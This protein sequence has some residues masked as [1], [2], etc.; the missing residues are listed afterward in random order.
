MGAFGKII[1][2]HYED[3][4]SGRTFSN[5][6]D[7]V[8]NP[9]A[10]FPS[11]G[12]RTE[13]DIHNACSGPP[14]AAYISHWHKDTRTP[15]LIG[16]KVD[17]LNW[18]VY[19]YEDRVKRVASYVGCVIND[20][21]ERFCAGHARARL[22]L[23]VRDYLNIQTHVLGRVKEEIEI[24]GFDSEAPE[25]NKSGF[26]RSLVSVDANVKRGLVWLINKGILTKS[27]FSEGLFGKVPEQVLSLFPAGDQPASTCK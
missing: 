21:P 7:F 14:M 16:E 22:V 6:S 4:F 26:D 23:I 2:D 18:P 17:P 27:D 11:D 1:E 9:Q 19:G 10:A 13:L 24:Y 15:R 25:G 12:D 5:L 8:R 20:R 3:A